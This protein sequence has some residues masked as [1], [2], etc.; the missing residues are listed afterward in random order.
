MKANVIGGMLLI[1]MCAA[2]SADQLQDP[3]S[4]SHSETVLAATFGEDLAFLE[5]HTQTIVLSDA[6]GQGKVVL[7]PAW[8]GRVMTSTAQGDGGRSLGWIN[9]KHIATGTLVPH[10]NVFGGEERFWLGPEGGQFSIFHGKDKG[11]GWDN[12]QVPAPLDSLPF[13]VTSRARDRVTFRSTFA[14][15]NYSGTNFQVEVQREVRL[16][17]TGV[18]WRY[19]G[20]APSSQ[21]SVVAFESHNKLTNV[22]TEP[23]RKGSGLLSIWI[24]GMHPSSPSAVF[25]APIKAGNSAELG[26]EVAPDYFGPL[27]SDRLKI[28]RDAVYFLVD[29]GYQSKIGI[30][31]RRSLGKFGSYDP[32]HRVLTIVNFTQHS[33]QT[34]YVKSVWRQQEEPYAGDA[35]NSYN[36]GPTTPGAETFGPFYE[37]ESS[38]AAAALEPGA[39]IDHMHRT[40]HLIGAEA[41]LEK[42]ARAALGVSLNVTFAAGLQGE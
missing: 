26:N 42:I 38:S 12:W 36:D 35:I 7:A 39:S 13:E 34:D 18:A 8:Q 24:A 30:S 5:R 20:L 41:E 33:G 2:C 4:H 28:T 14:L 40:I 6:T 11:F 19:L 1:A 17:N 22:G 23:W 32:K 3:N 31:P 21:V 29:A 15:S 25:M 27:K 16:L 10:M 37:M 9:H